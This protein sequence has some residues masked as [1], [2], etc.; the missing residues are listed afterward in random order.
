MRPFSAVLARS[1]A[2]KCLKRLA[3]QVGLEPTTLRLTAEWLIV[4][5]RCKHNYLDA[6]N[7]DYCVNWGDFGGTIR[8]VE[9]KSLRNRSLCRSQNCGSSSRRLAMLKPNATFSKK[10]QRS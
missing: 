7:A 3:P 8:D 1:K 9:L 10:S 5:S 6:R 4:A 2:C